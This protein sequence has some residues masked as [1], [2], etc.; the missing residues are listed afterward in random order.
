METILITGAN[1]GL[2]LE[3]V[4]Q[5]LAR[6][7]K[8]IACCRAPNEAVELQALNNDG[9]EIFPLDVGNEKA[10]Q[11]LPGRLSGTLKES[12]IAMFINNAGI[13]GQTQSLDEADPE[14]WLQ[15][16]RINTIAPFL[17]TR[18]LLPLMDSQ[19]PGKLIF[20]SSKMGSIAD[21]GGGS[22]YI[23]RTS[24][25]ALNQVMKSLSIDLADQGL[26]TAALH[27]GWVRTDMGGPNGLIDANESVS[28]MMRVIDA[29]DATT[30]GRFFNF[31]GAEISW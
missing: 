21:N 29:L 26:L 8:V 12:K 7:D 11:S 23:Y 24:K 3:F 19:L 15:V 22:T 30:S 10:I 9:L 31:D 25:A 13:Y 1:R 14:E 16:F 28:G 27:P 17:L 6:G 18:A 4:R 5:F 2:G 20:L